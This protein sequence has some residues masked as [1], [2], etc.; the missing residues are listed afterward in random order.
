M[1]PPAVA[2]E[3]AVSSFSIQQINLC[4]DDSAG[5]IKFISLLGEKKI[6]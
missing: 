5:I 6:K 3:S 4:V 1:R 2:A